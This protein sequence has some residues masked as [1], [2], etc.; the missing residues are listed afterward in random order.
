MG[1]GPID[2]HRRGSPGRPRDHR[3]GSRSARRIRRRRARHHL[4]HRQPHPGPGRGRGRVG[5]VAGSG[6]A[7]R[8]RWVDRGGPG[9]SHR[10]ARRRAGARS[11][12]GP[13]GAGAVASGAAMSSASGSK[14]LGS[15]C[16]D[17]TSGRAVRGG[18]F[19]GLC[20]GFG[21]DSA[22]GRSGAGIDGGLGLGR[23]RLG[24]GQFGDV[25]Q[26]R[27]GRGRA[28]GPDQVVILQRRPGPGRHA[29]RAVLTPRSSSRLSAWKTS[30][31]TDGPRSGLMGCPSAPGRRHER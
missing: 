27:P 24:C 3:R 20:S 2:R 15:P 18:A 26:S 5:L 19:S 22:S 1:S 7:G 30:Q 10:R 11:V 29:R 31:L 13:W 23:A 17:G 14:S 9:T 21:F 6:Q 4:P 16:R 12:S 25:G 8:A 28:R